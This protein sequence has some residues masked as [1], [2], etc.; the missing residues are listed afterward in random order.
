MLLVNIKI[1]Y[2]CQCTCFHMQACAYE[3]NM[4]VSLQYVC[5]FVF[6]LI[7]ILQLQCDLYFSLSV[8]IHKS[9]Y[10]CYT[11]DESLDLNK[12]LV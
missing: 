6:S 10:L 11:E 2:L 1:L 12:L 7:Q 3:E 9:F 5:T 4:F 8:C